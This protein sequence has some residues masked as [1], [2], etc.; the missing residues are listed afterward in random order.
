MKLPIQ[1]QAE[2]PVEII[3]W[4][5]TPEDIERIKKEFPDIKIIKKYR[6]TFNVYGESGYVDTYF[7]PTPGG[8]GLELFP[9]CYIFKN[10]C[11]SANKEWNP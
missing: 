8:G 5:G 2:D 10:Y 1:K 7:I 3:K 9:G 11:V 6:P 4:E